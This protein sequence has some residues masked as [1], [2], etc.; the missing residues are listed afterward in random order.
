MGIRSP[1]IVVKVAQPGVEKLKQI[2]FS[3]SS[4]SDF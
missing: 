4:L 2:Q 3:G 1:A